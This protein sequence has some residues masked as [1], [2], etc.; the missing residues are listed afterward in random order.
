MG[1]PPLSGHLGATFYRGY[2]FSSLDFHP[3]LFLSSLSSAHSFLLLTTGAKE[4]AAAGGG[5]GIETC[6]QVGCSGT[7]AV[8][9]RLNGY[10]YSGVPVTLR[11]HIAGVVL[12]NVKCSFV[13]SKFACICLTSFSSV[14]STPARLVEHQ[15]ITLR[16]NVSVHKDHL[17][18]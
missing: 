5:L 8:Q 17:F 1:L 4:K 3:Y 12:L 11:K 16:W 13:F 14:L 7:S 2:F 15:S 9:P 10:R 18:S 6:N